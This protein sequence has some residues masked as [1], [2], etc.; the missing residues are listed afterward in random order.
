MKTLILL[1]MNSA[2]YKVKSLIKK[3]DYCLLLSKDYRAYLKL[4]SIIPDD[5]KVHNLKGTVNSEIENIRKEYLEL[6]TD[7]NHKHDSFAWW[8]THIASRNSASINLQLHIT[9]LLCANK[10]INNFKDNQKYKRLIFIADSQALLDCIELIC[11]ES[12]LLL[13]KNNNNLRR[14]IYYNFLSAKYLFNIIYFLMDSYKNRLLSLFIM[15]RNSFIENNKLIVIRSWITSDTLSNNGMYIDRN[16]GILPTTLASKGYKVLIQ[17]ML[18]NYH[19]SMIKYY[20]LLKKQNVEFLLAEHFLIFIDYLKAIYLSWVQ[21]NI[22]L[23]NIILS[24][25]DITPLFHEIQISQGF[26]RD[27]LKHNLSYAFFA[28]LKLSKPKIDKFYYAFENNISEKPFILSCKKYFPESEIIGY[29]H[30]CLYDKQ[31]GMFLGNEESQQH[32][33]PDKIICSG[34]VYLT[35]LKN[36]GFPVSRLYMGP[37][38]RFTA[39]NKNKYVL[40]MKTLKPSIL[41]PL[42]FDLDLAYDLISKVKD[43]TKD[44]P[45]ILIF[46]RRHPFLNFKLLE[47]FIKEIKLENTNYADSGTIQDWLLKSDLVLS[48]G[49]SIVILETVAAG[50]PMIRIEPDN[51][52]LLDPLAWTDYPINPLNN[53]DEIKSEIRKILSYKNVD[54]DN[55]QSIGNKLKH[56]Y[57]SEIN[58][59]SMKIFE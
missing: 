20:L 44:F 35:L 51:N 37:N 41:L 3:D 49:S 2:K 33:I 53:L 52:F 42:T 38:L 57:Y 56:N 8:A 18:F 48:T 36:A 29:Q 7:L 19:K 10:F 1:K 58:D 5:C 14:F 9:Y 39:V 23:N 15:K 26:S 4:N 13:I 50:V 54:I 59:S 22:P 6:F 24:S 46:I 31:L 27:V 11:K 55:L 21:V 34:P 30:T 28:R 45:E 12:N 32:P 40:K 43:I 16:F 47:Q 25:I 17:P